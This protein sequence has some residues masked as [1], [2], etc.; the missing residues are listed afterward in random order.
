MQLTL[1]ASAIEDSEQV[2]P[3][4]P[5]RAVILVVDDEPE[6]LTLLG[7]VL[8]ATG[9]GVLSASDGEDAL[10]ISR[11]Y[12]GTIHAVLTDISMPK[13]DG[14]EL[15]RRISTERP[16]I[17]VLL[18]SGYNF[19]MP[20]GTPLMKKPLDLVAVRQ[21]IQHLLGSARRTRRAGG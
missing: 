14:L 17:K 10:E 15:K 11:E 8:H 9:F 6:V 12:P 20:D 21:H 19:S 5:H 16:G 18:M 3:P 1:G 2:C 13:M 4:D 7:R